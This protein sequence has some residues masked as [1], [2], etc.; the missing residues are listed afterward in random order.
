MRRFLSQSNEDKFDQRSLL[1]PQTV[2]LTDLLK[3][4]LMFQ[5]R[6]EGLW[7]LLIES[8]SA[9]TSEDP[10]NRSYL[11]FHFLCDLGSLE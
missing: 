7:Y 6:D 1:E 2:S 5:Q 4:V 3:V 8:S 10:V 9:L 11:S